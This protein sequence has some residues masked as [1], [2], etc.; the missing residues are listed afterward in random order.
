MSAVQELN[1][2]L[3]ARPPALFEQLLETGRT[4]WTPIIDG[5]EIPDQP[6]YLFEIG[7]FSHVP[8]MLGAN[9]DEGWTF[10]NRSFQSS[11]TIDQYTTTLD[12]EFGADAA[13]ILETYP[14]ADSIAEGRTGGPVGTLS[15][16]ARRAESRAD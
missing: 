9:R 15:M 8:V 1:Q 5:V 3:F 12:S 14:V 10:V 6:R 11:V 13:A 7:A 2:V 16:F 4:Q